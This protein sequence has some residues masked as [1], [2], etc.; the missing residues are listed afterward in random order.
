MPDLQFLALG[1]MGKVTQ[2][3]YLYEYGQEMLLVDCGIGFPDSHMPGVDI[4]IPDISYVLKKLDQGKRIVGMILTHGHDDHIAATGYLLEHLPAFPI[5]ASPLTAIFATDRMQDGAVKRLVTTVD[6]SDPFTL[7]SFTIRM[8]PV[9]HSIPDTRHLAI[10][11]PEGTIYHGSDFKLDSAPVDGVKTDMDLI[12][13]I[14]EEG[15]LCMLI[16]C[17]RIEKTERTES[18]STVGPTILETMTNTKGRYVMT[19]MSS[20]IH[21]IQQ[22]VDAAEKFNRK[23]AFIGRSVER[24]VKDAL[25][26]KKLYIPSGLLIDKTDIDRYHPHELCIIVAGSQG[27]E[28]SSM[29]RAIYGEHRMLQITGQDTVVFSADAIPGNELNYFGAI[30]ELS[31]HQVHVL[32][33]DILPGLH[34]SGH[35]SMPEQQELV[36]AVRPKY[37]MPIG[38]ADRHRFLFKTRVAEPLHYKKDQVLLPET[39]EVIQISEHGIRT[40]ERVT[41]RPPVIDGLGVGDVG[42][43]VLSD[44]LALGEAGIVVITL[45]RDRKNGF[46]LRK[47]SVVSKGFIFMKDAQ[48]VVEF[49]KQSVGEIVTKEGKKKDD[50]LKRMIERRLS[51][52]LYKIIKREPLIVSVIL[53]I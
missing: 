36:E 53:D 47:T 46:D 39:G 34:K 12:R 38:G 20:H 26:L 23:I 31:R 10:T 51:R 50:D 48:E 33:P 19:L 44:R 13:K 25:E 52:K 3:M 41:L 11:T 30:D 4:L 5:F 29:M 37:L 6:N 49:I 21:R 22:V 24:N 40:V 32:Y 9:T 17:L 1:G 15:V 7:G 8:I 2:N 28:G 27:Q 43:V 16:D 45:V 18:E 14:G 35:A 42:P